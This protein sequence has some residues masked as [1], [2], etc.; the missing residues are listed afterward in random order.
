[1]ESR[2]HAEVAMDLQMKGD[3]KRA[4]QAWERA[5]DGAGDNR[6]AIHQKAAMCYQRLNDRQAARR[7]FTEAIRGFKE[8]IEAGKDVDRARAAIQACE[9]ALGGSR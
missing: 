3:Y 9:A 7:H 8:Q 1:M 2:N 5:L 6:A 4:A